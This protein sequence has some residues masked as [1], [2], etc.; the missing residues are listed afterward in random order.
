MEFPGKR[1]ADGGAVADWLPG[2][3]RE[4]ERASDLLRVVERYR[5]NWMDA[6]GKILIEAWLRLVET[7]EEGG[8]ALP[9]AL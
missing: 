7:P 1:V 5:E 6:S 4:R 9:P 3:G 2:S 8:G